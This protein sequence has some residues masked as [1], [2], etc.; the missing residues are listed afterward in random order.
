MQY[1]SGMTTSSAAKRWII[2]AVVVVLLCGLGA[3]GWWS[4][5]E[6][7]RLDMERRALETTHQELQ[8]SIASATEQARS[9]DEAVKNSQQYEAE[10]KAKAARVRNLANGLAVISSVKTATTEYFLSEGHW[11]KSNAAAGLPRPGEFKAP[12]VYSVSVEPEGKIRVEINDAGRRSDIYMFAITN[13]AG[14]VSWQCLSYSIPDIA[15]IVPACAYR[16]K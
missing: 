11:P 16:S 5:K 9:L 8:Q 7:D 4:G 3:L 10:Q 12:G 15:K 1:D 14:Q 13:K 2:G 6:A